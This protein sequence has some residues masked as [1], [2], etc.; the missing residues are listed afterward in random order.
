MTWARWGVISI[1][2]AIDDAGQI[3]GLSLLYADGVLHDLG[4]LGENSAATRGINYS[5][6]I[7]G[8]LHNS[9]GEGHTFLLFISP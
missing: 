6:N 1:A 8:Y 2:R 9:T 7:V 3:V 4:T 5:E